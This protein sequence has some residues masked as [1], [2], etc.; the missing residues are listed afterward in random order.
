MC[1][2]NELHGRVAQKPN[3]LHERH[4]RKSCTNR[5]NERVARKSCTNELHEKVSQT[6]CM[7]K[8]T[9]TSCMKKKIGEKVFNSSANC[10]MCEFSKREPHEI[11]EHLRIT[12]IQ[13]LAVTSHTC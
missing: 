9:R 1:C 11:D 13:T 2:T 5:L 3:E 12:D 7:K 6:S 4:A 10:V 8:V